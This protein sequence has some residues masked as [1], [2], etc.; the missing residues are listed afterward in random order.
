MMTS[1]DV[2]LFI[3]SNQDGKVQNTRSSFSMTLPRAITRGVDSTISVNQVYI[4]SSFLTILK[5]STPHI[6]IEMMQ[7]F[8]PGV[9][10][11]NDKSAQ[12]NFYGE[13]PWYTV[14]IYFEDA[15]II[16]SA[17]AAILINDVMT[18]YNLINVLWFTLTRDGDK[19][20]INLSKDI[21]WAG[22]QPE[23][24]RTL[25][26]EDGEVHSLVQ[27]ANGLQLENAGE[28]GSYWLYGYPYTKHVVEAKNRLN[29]NVYVP[30]TFC[31][32]SREVQSSINGSQSDKMMLVCPGPLENDGK[33]YCYSPLVQVPHTFNADIISELNIT[34]ARCDTGGVIPLSVGSAT[35]I[36]CNIGE[37]GHQL[38]EVKNLTCFSNDVNSLHVFPENNKALFSIQ[39]GAPITK[40]PYKHWNFKLMNVSISKKVRN[41]TNR[42]CYFEMSVEN[43]EWVRVRFDP[44]FY[45]TVYDVVENINAKIA[46]KW[47]ARNMNLVYAV[48]KNHV[49][50]MNNGQKDVSIKMT[51]VLAS[52]FGFHEAIGDEDEVLFEVKK[53]SLFR[54]QF[55]HNINLGRPRYLKVLCSQVEHTIMGGGQECVLSFC[56]LDSPSAINEKILFFDFFNPMQVNVDGDN[57]S[58]LDFVLSSGTTTESLEFDDDDTV[59]THLSIMMTRFNE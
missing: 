15:R 40:Y 16:S 22:L 8:R 32:R 45:K 41:I 59:P 56:A 26:F 57:I 14:F 51:S 19:L 33:I 18:R 6:V 5:G 13:G 31:L 55:P 20:E 42:N 34:L 10:S 37:M 46:K 52:V 25:G 23:F 17:N 47:Q 1:K 21:L 53:D 28:F 12:V 43:G 11:I 39:L 3:L 54:L 49:V 58:R 50:V 29:R 2:S 48:S 44:G 27:L 30:S 24:A 35:Y 36:R 7:E 4:E 38:Q 9:N